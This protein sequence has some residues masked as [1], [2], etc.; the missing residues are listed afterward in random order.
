MCFLFILLQ[1]INSKNIVHGVWI[2]GSTIKWLY[3]AQYSMIVFSCERTVWVSIVVVLVSFYCWKEKRGKTSSHSLV[4]VYENI[5]ESMP[6]FFLVC[7]LSTDLMSRKFIVKC[8]VWISSSSLS[9]SD[10]VICDGKCPSSFHL[11]LFCI[12]NY[13][14]S[15]WNDT[16]SLI[17]N[18]IL[19]RTDK[20]NRYTATPKWCLIVYT[21]SVQFFVLLPS[22][23]ALGRVVTFD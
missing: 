19:T 13:K 11:Y 17:S 23:F 2:G 9:L 10:A 14:W 15:V 1:F 4:R 8:I 12:G 20:K 16:V 18:S 21:A 3:H 6:D 22:H 5:E 7:E